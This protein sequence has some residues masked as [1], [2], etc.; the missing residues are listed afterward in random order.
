M[1]F[2]CSRKASSTPPKWD[3]DEYE[4]NIRPE[5]IDKIK[6][7]HTYLGIFNF[8]DFYRLLY[9]FWFLKIR[10]K[11]LWWYAGASNSNQFEHWNQS[12]VYILVRL[13]KFTPQKVVIC[14]LF[15]VPTYSRFYKARTF[16][17]IAQGKARNWSARWFLQFLSLESTVPFSCHFYSY[18][19]PYTHHLQVGL[20]KFLRLRI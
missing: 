4:E 17:P 1:A 3:Q 11:A 6:R 16:A 20:A 12:N 5:W 2:R 19:A 15:N 13:V 14:Q 18:L 10:D 9:Q 8:Y 7:E